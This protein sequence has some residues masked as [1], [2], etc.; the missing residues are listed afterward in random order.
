MSF[1]HGVVCVNFSDNVTLIMKWKRRH[2]AIVV[3]HTCISSQS[4][5]IEAIICL[6]LVSNNRTCRMWFSSHPVSAGH[7]AKFLLMTCITSGR[8]CFF[9]YYY[10]VFP[11]QADNPLKAFT[12]VS[13]HLWL[14]A[15][16]TAS[17]Y[18][19]DCDFYSS[20]LL[21]VYITHNELIWI[22]HSLYKI[23]KMD[24]KSSTMEQHM[25]SLLC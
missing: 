8:L 20:P 1:F 13:C 15:A 3:L 23:D 5:P 16:G 6:L 25:P 19:L 11:K 14:T 9:D 12:Y 4:N 18:H 21:P 10:L 2:R 17:K 24:N 7:Q 22:L